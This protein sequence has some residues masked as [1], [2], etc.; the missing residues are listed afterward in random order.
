MTDSQRLR[1]AIRNK[2]LKYT[3][4]AA[5]L[6]ISTYALQLKIDNHN[7]F[8]VSEVNKLVELLALKVKER[9]IIFFTPR[10]DLKSQND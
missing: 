7:E 5:Q 10:S 8:K 9:D 3:F 6:G 4:I 1:E 2:G